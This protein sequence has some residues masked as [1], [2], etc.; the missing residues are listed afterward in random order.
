M[1][2][3]KSQHRRECGV[4]TTI[5]RDDRVITVWRYTMSLKEWARAKLRA[6]RL[7]GLAPQ[8]VVNWA[9]QKGLR[10]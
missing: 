3:V 5:R 8:H 1:S 6:P 7:G 4:P 9:F 2:T 10:I